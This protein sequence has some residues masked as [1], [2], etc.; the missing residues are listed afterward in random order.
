MEQVKEVVVIGCCTDICVFNLAISLKSY[1]DENKMIYG[2]VGKSRQSISDT[3]DFVKYI[4]I[5]DLINKTL[6]PKEKY[7]VIEN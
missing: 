7:I 2:L 1:F 5:S 6:T 4:E 3:N